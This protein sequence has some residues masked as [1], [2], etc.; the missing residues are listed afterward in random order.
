MESVKSMEITAMEKKKN[1]EKL[2]R[3]V[4]TLFRTASSNHMKLSAWLLTKLTYSLA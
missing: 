2:E 3:G 1:K 4:E